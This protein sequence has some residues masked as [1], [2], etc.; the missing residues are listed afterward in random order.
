MKLLSTTSH[1]EPSQISHIP[2]SLF[3]LLFFA[4]FIFAALYTSFTALVPF[5]SNLFLH[6]YFFD[7]PS[8]LS[9]STIIPTSPKVIPEDV[10]APLYHST[11]TIL[12]FYISFT[13]FVSFRTFSLN[14]FLGPYCFIFF[15]SMTYRLFSFPS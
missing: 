14:S 3:L 1:Y 12:L 7:L 6:L 2:H 13:N 9:Y 10:Q 15:S 11:I 8:I 4:Y 5:R